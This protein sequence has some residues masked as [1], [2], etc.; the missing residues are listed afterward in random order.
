[1]G[2]RLLWGP[3]SD[4]IGRGGTFGV[5]GLIGVPALMLLPHATS[6]VAT[7][8]S[9]ALQLFQTASLLNVGVFAGGPVRLQLNLT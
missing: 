5:F 6:M 8:P 4:R 2:G 3:I 9:T 7:Q 1:M